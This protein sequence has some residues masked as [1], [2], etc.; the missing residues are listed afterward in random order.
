MKIA[1]LPVVLGQ[2]RKHK[3]AVQQSMMTA[4]QMPPVLG[5]VPVPTGT[6]SAY[7]AG[8]EQAKKITKVAVDPGQFKAQNEVLPF[9]AYLSRVY[10][11]PKTIRN[12]YQRIFD[13]INSQPKRATGLVDED[14]DKIYSYDFFN[15]PAN[16]EDALVGMDV[17]IHRL[18]KVFKAAASGGE[19]GRRVILLEG[20]VASAKSTLV[21][22][23]KRGM[24]VDSRTEQGAL[25]GLRWHNLPE[26][27]AKGL[28]LE[29]DQV[30][31]KAEYNLDEPMR[32]DPLTVIPNDNN[33]LT[34]LLEDINKDFRAKS[35]GA[36]PYR[37][38][39]HT[40]LPPVSDMV[41]YRLMEYY[42]DKLGPGEDL[43]EKVLQHVQA[44][45]VIMDETKRVGIGTYMPKDAKNQD[46]T[47][48]NGDIDYVEFLKHGDI[49]HPFVQNYRG[50][51]NIANRGMIEM[52]EM[53]K[54][55]DEFLYDLLTAGQEREIK[56]KHAP[57]IP[58][59]FVIFGHT[60]E[61]EFEKMIKNKSMEA[62]QNRILRV[63]VPYVLNYREEMGIYRKGFVRMAK[64]KN[65]AIAPHALEMACLWAVLTRLRQ[66]T[67]GTSLLE[68]ARAY[69]GESTKTL[70]PGELFYE[71]REA[72][73]K[74]EGHHGVSARFL[75]TVLDLALTHSEV[76]ETKT[77]TPFLLLKGI[78]KELSEGVINERDNIPKY[79]ELVGDIEKTL[80]RQVKSDIFEAFL[81]TTG[82]ASLKYNFEKYINNLQQWQKQTGKADE[83]FMAFIEKKFS[84]A[85]SES[86]VKKF[87]QELLDRL[88]K[89]GAVPLEFVESDQTLRGA[90]R[91][92]IVQDELV[93][94]L[95]NNAPDS[96]A[97]A[98]IVGHLKQT[99]GYNEF[100]AREA[101]Q[102]IKTAT[103][104]PAGK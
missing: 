46:S 44:K 3:Q 94:L 82:K 60:N 9:E 5:Y 26:E 102:F 49:T 95:E 67:A 42:N 15:N 58:V 61:P 11:N 96:P 68:K 101:L 76:E 39:L 103:P 33:T 2:E 40:E 45:R 8:L 88:P 34:Q 69:A 28:K 30:G 16:G 53:L 12:A 50:E 57:Q 83:G 75:Q 54:L 52:V 93:S 55:Q 79:L 97:L 17:P 23:I 13:I 73:K 37:L 91:D 59:D 4:P 14:G 89:S 51:F 7:F 104:A 87:R 47:E 98:P 36:A 80:A 100:S 29:A 74:G 48:L 78:R 81:A 63:K 70:T 10:E 27:V 92:K 64:E 72:S 38:K 90:I 62:L 6:L 35:G 71:K 84:P 41:R 43:M 99:L 85:L 77:V 18:V 56:P 22:L 31:G 24:E 25:Y 21:R 20:P 1:S 86:E 19:I 32:V 66:G 65:I